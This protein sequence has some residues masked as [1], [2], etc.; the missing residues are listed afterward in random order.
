MSQATSYPVHPVAMLVAKD[1]SI[2]VVTSD[3]LSNTFSA[4]M[5]EHV[6]H[7]GGFLLFSGAK[8]AVLYLLLV[9]HQLHGQEFQHQDYHSRL[10]VTIWKAIS[11]DKSTI[12]GNEI[13]D[14][15]M[16]AGFLNQYLSLWK[17]TRN[18]S[19]L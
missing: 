10:S 1:I 2:Q 8:V 18:F 14:D 12:M 6:S 9:S 11:A 7:G 4:T 19:R 5:E 16:A 13:S 17:M 3:Q 15:E